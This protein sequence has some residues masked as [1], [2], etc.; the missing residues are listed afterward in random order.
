MEYLSDDPTYLAGGLALI[1]GAFLIALRLTQEGKYLVRAVVAFALALGVVGVERVWVTDNERIEQTVYGLAEAVKASDADGVLAW[2]T[3]DV[4]YVAGGNS[5]PSL[6]TRVLI[7]K[8][9]K[10][11]RFDFLQ[12]LHL[13]ASAGGQSRR[14]LAEFGVRCGGSFQGSYNALNFAAANSSWS[15]GL[16][17]TA[18]GV[19]KVYRITPV[20]L[21]GGQNV[22]P[23]G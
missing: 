22:L 15:L 6:A 11:A 3:P 4:Q 12:I 19:W 16:R 9:V 7:E 23:T 13:R 18:P 5:W 2:L 14:G 10:N 21:P 8:N 17:E 1:G 20:S